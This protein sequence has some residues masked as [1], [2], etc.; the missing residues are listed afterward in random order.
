MVRIHCGV[1]NHGGPIANDPWQRGPSR[2]TTPRVRL[3][4]PR[5]PLVIAGAWNRAVFNPEWV[6]ENLL[7]PSSGSLEARIALLPRLAIEYATEL[8]A[9]GIEDGRLFIVPRIATSECF[10]EVER[11]AVDILRLLPQTPLAGVGFNVGYDVEDPPRDLL[12]L[13]ELSDAP[14][15][16]QRGLRPVATT[17]SRAFQTDRGL[18]KVA[19]HLQPNQPV[20]FDVNR[21]HDVR[22]AAM[23]ATVVPGGVSAAVA[24]ASKLA[25]ELY[26]L[27]VTTP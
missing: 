10:D 26:N 24:E 23:A 4:L 8:V 18:L 22:N 21:H 13:F 11:L 20:R 16:L 19:I 2:D 5:S 14:A 6:G 9:L 7:R 17:V 15:L 12:E 27:K 25:Q 3:D 1:Q